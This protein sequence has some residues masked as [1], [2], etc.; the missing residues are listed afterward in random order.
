MAYELTAMQ[1]VLHYTCH[2]VTDT[3]HVARWQPCC[4]PGAGHSR[5][6]DKAQHQ[7]ALGARHCIIHER[8]RRPLSEG[9]C[10]AFERHCQVTAQLPRRGCEPNRLHI[11]L[12]LQLV[13]ANR[14]SRPACANTRHAR[15]APQAPAALQCRVAAAEAMRTTGLTQGTPQRLKGSL[16]RSRC[17]P[18]GLA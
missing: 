3:V 1:Q 12:L 6:R 14:E 16:Y 5:H 15:W 11:C 8:L 9:V 4:D 13:N 18:V 17:T 10:S 7:D 2:L